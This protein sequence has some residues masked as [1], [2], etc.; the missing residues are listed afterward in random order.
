MKILIIRFSSI[1]DII[2][3]TPVIRCIKKQLNA[4]IHFLVK[5]NFASVLKH[6][7][8]ID[9]H[10]VYNKEIIETLK[11]EKYDYVIDLHKSQLSTKVK[12]KL[13]VKSYT[14]N[15]VNI[16]K[17]LFVNFKINLLPEKHLV[18]R[19]FDGLK[20]LGIANDGQ[21]L[22]YHFVPEEISEIKGIEYES[23]VLGSAHNTK[24]ITVELAQKIIDKSVTKVVLLGGKDVI[25]QS[26][27]LVH[28]EKV[29]NLVDRTNFNQ[30]ANIIAKSKLT[31]AGDTGLMHMAAA[32][33]VPLH[34]YWG[35]TSKELGMFPYYGDFKVYNKSFYVEGLRCRPCSK[36]G[37][38]SC[39]KGH[40]KCMKDIVI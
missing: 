37:Y 33:K 12:W 26:K 1:G 24:R 27:L 11:G 22:D 20:D 31:H 28:N 21:G 35:N 34:V 14:Y 8:Y 2:V 9:K 36:L 17:W 23:I 10:I 29:I 7:E 5:E 30:A 32:L 18:D 40:F 3:T 16:E 6:N 13:G 15:K 38:E 19:Y 4:E 25:E 39:P